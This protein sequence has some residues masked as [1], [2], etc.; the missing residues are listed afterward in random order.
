MIVLYC[1]E[2]RIIVDLII[3]HIRTW[4][5]D[6]VEMVILVVFTTKVCM[7][8]KLWISYDLYILRYSSISKIIEIVSYLKGNR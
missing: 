7:V 2:L 3:I 6:S 8:L 5:V 1:T 4:S